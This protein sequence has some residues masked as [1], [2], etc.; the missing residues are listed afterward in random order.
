MPWDAGNRVST[1][2]I[3]AES[4][5]ER[6]RAR[7][8]KTTP[9]PS[10]FDDNTW[11]LSGLMEMGDS[12]N[13]YTISYGGDGLWYCSCYD[14][15]GGDLRAEKVCSHAAAVS[16]FT[17][18]PCLRTQALKDKPEPEPEPQIEVIS[19]IA[20]VVPF[21]AV[22]NR[23]CDIP[24]IPRRYTEWREHQKEAVEWA[25]EQI[26]AGHRFVILDAPPGSGK[27][28]SAIC[29]A[30]LAGLK[31]LYIVCNR[32][33]QEQVANDFPDAVVIWG[34]EHYKC[35][36]FPQLTAAECVHR[37]NDP[38]DMIGAC[39]YKRLK[40]RAADHSQLVV[41]NYSYFIIEANYIGRFADWPLV[42][43]DEGDVAPDELGKFVELSI[44]TKQLNTCNIEPPRF[45][46]KLD[47]WLEWAEPTIDKVQDYVNL[48]EKQAMAYSE[49]PLILMRDLLHYERLLGKL[50]MFQE[51]VDKDW[52]PE[53]NNPE[54]WQFRPCW[55][56]RVGNK[57]LYGKQFLIMS[58][59]M[60]PTDSWGWQLG[61]EEEI[62]F[63][64]VP[65]TF[66]KENRPFIYEPAADFSFK[67]AKDADFQRMVRILDLK[68]DEHQGKGLIHTVTY[69]LAKYV[70][71]YS[72]HQ[73]RLITHGD[74]GTR[75]EALEQLIESDQP[76][77][78][79]S[80]SFTRGVDLFG[81]RAVFQII[82][83]I[84]YLDLSDKQTQKRRWSGKKGEQ[85]YLEES[86]RTIIQMAMRIIRSK[87][88]RYKPTYMLDERWPDFY[89]QVEK[90][91]APWFK[92][93][94]V[95]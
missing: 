8:L 33:L 82:C 90:Y 80:P 77:V 55:V 60:P 43:F 92:E 66:P 3:V 13:E 94:L 10:I 34:R 75:A 87:E 67:K 2:T 24:G 93:A 35:P 31:C 70:L 81:E 56:N 52:I 54:K 95:W 37:E 85:W 88:E 48:L 58:G 59:T 18:L 50:R 45:K 16:L 39:E 4:T 46:T 15:K 42:I 17:K 65:S 40:K 25:L 41:L 29:I 20:P 68:L 14:H 47:A 6:A 57:L 19:Q 69:N 51:V 27:S 11:S 1:G 21:G 62:P 12:Y 86:A 61:I 22:P 84:P 38:C 7:L 36:R 71:E 78:L 83:K 72:R 30:K 79:V 76:L 74:S 53:F 23:P 5:W 32:Q 44:S 28:L 63:H 73:D 64:R 9:F 26:R 49:P 89:N 91:L